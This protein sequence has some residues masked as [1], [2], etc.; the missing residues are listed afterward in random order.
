MNQP[1]T[2]TKVFVVVVLFLLR[3]QC[4]EREMRLKGVRT[5]KSTCLR[6]GTASGVRKP[7]QVQASPVPAVQGDLKELV[8][9][10]G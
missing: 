10:C 4:V 7:T 6:L 5:H 2:R 1:V 8:K 3:S 9:K